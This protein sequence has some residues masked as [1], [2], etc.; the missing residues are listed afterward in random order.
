MRFPPVMSQRAGASRGTS[1]AREARPHGAPLCSSCEAR[2]PARM[3]LW[4]KFGG[5]SKSGK[6]SGNLCVAPVASGCDMEA[7]PCDG[8]YI[9]S[10]A[11]LGS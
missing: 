7:E 5:G 6:S 4:R 10:V 9:S 11:S 1:F 8:H 2:L 3:A